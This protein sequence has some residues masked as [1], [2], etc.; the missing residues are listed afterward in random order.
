MVVCVVEHVR[1]AARGG[2]HLVRR[3]RRAGV[4]QCES[5]PSCENHGTTCH[6]LARRQ[7]KGIIYS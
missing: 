4:I 2:V 1:F 5:Q 3:A 7:F 6:D